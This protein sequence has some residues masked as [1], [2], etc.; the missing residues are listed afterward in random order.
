[1]NGSKVCGAGLYGRVKNGR[2]VMIKRLFLG[3]GLWIVLF[4]IAPHIGWAQPAPGG[5]PDKLDGLTIMK[6]SRD[7]YSFKD[8]IATVT[9][10]LIDKDGSERKI[11]T[12]RLWKNYSGQDDLDSKTLFWTEFPPENKGTGFLI[13]DYA[14]DGKSD[15]LWLYLPSLRQSR[16]MT[17]RDQDDAFMGSDLTFADMGQRRL[18]ED[19]HTLM[20]E[21]QI[22]NIPCYVVQS[23]PKEKNSIYSK[24][25]SCI[26]KKDWLTLKTDYYD[27]KGDLL[28]TQNIDWQEKSGFHIYK[29]MVVKN[30]QT[31][32]STIFTMS[33]L[34]LDN[35][36][37]DDELT[38]RALK[39]GLRR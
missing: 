19:V 21:S 6:K 27:R 39:T 15:D 5:A 4:A 10:Q 13:W 12:R 22:N 33:N 38:E 17:T 16:R 3:M 18:D 2:L 14:T 37:K 23:V 7:L 20:G 35:G 36:L 31:G 24:R 26:S 29:Q 8:Q 28:K 25:V 30:A 32:H 11:V 1:M 34:K 9:L